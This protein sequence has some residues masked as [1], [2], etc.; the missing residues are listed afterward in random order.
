MPQ[1]SSVNFMWNKLCPVDRKG[2]RAFEKS[3][4][5]RLEKLG[6]HKSDPS[7]LTPDEIERF[8]K[9]DID[10]ATITWRRV[11]DTS[12]RYLRTVSVGEAPTEV[13]KK[14][15]EQ[16]NRSANFS[17]TVASEVTPRSR[18]DHATGARRDRAESMRPR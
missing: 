5:P 6:I 11:T 7:E 2:R 8:V 4:L 16:L 12:D 1:T 18:R 3:M 14:T 17:I 15:G 9:L 13:H 10:P